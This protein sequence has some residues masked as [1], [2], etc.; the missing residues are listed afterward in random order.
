[1]TAIKSW[2]LARS[3]WGTFLLAFW[4]YIRIEI[5]MFFEIGSILEVVIFFYEVQ[6]ICLFEVAHLHNTKHFEVDCF[7]EIKWN[8]SCWCVSAI[9][10]V[11]LHN[12]FSFSFWSS[13][14]NLLMDITTFNLIASSNAISIHFLMCP[15]YMWQ[16]M[17]E[18]M[19][20]LKCRREPLWSLVFKVKIFIIVL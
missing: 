18:L 4:R 8:N 11:R 10:K 5:L 2:Q 20:S 17:E 13:S 15:L 12:V 14:S 16:H 7:K 9:S 1:M 19:L 3:F 6:L